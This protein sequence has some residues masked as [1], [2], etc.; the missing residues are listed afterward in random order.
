M[1]YSRHVRWF[2]SWGRGLPSHV[3]THDLVHKITKTLMTV[4]VWLYCVKMLIGALHY[5]TGS[6]RGLDVGFSLCAVP[7]SYSC[8]SILGVEL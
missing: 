1:G 2:V 8:L 7:T 5:S 3:E 4:G 6:E